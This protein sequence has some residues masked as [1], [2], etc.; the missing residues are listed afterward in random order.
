[1]E[2]KN[3]HITN[4]ARQ[5]LKQRFDKAIAAGEI[6]IGTVFALGSRPGKKRGETEFFAK[7]TKGND[8]PKLGVICGVVT[9][10]G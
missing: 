10:C 8:Y 6:P 5:A 2:G 4:E 3:M 7:D 1:M 9:I